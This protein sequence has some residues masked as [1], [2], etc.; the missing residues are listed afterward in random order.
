MVSHSS[1]PPTPNDRLPLPAKLAQLERKLLERLGEA[2]V[3]SLLMR[4]TEPTAPDA[5]FRNLKA[6]LAA[7]NDQLERVLLAMVAARQAPKLDQ[8]RIHPWVRSKLQD[9]LR[10]LRQGGDRNP[11]PVGEYLFEVRRNYAALRRFPAGPLDWVVSHFPRKWLLQA[12]GL[13]MVKQGWFVLRRMKGFSPVFFLHVA[14]R[15]RNRSLV[16]EKEVMRT[17]YRV[18]ASL[19]QQPEMLGIILASWFLDRQVLAD[20]PYLEYIHRLVVSA[21]GLITE[22]N[23]AP[24]DSGYLEHHPER[25]ARAQR[26]EIRFRIGAG[27]MPREAALAWMRAHPEYGE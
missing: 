17:Y 26:G 14:P 11:M 7:Q 3:E 18:A 8:Q 4:M 6:E 20:M 2:G 1:G 9:E 23:W 21:G 16:M 25:A 15:P 19:E 5:E 27:L 12:R 22:L 10:T 13:A 24:P